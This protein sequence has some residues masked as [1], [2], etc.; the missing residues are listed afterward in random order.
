M[1]ISFYEVVWKIFATVNRIAVDICQIASWILFLEEERLSHFF[2]SNSE[3]T[4]VKLN[5]LRII[6][7]FK[8]FTN[9][10]SKTKHSISE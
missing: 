2:Q 4:Q 9:K 1:I 7:K 3:K 5:L 10:M 8:G 6:T